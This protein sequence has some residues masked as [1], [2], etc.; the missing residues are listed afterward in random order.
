VTN[1]GKREE[2]R[3]ETEHATVLEGKRELKITQRRAGQSYL[4]G[5]EGRGPYIQNCANPESKY[6]Q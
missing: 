5:E 1:L 2:G 6:L 3:H 4:F